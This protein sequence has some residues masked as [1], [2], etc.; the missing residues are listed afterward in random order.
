[1]NNK[2]H[3]TR[4][5]YDKRRVV[6]WKA[7]Y[8][9]F[10][11]DLINDDFTVLE[12]GAGYC[13]FINQVKCRKKIAVDAWEGF[14]AYANEDVITKVCSVQKIDFIED[15]SI[16]FVF[17]SNLFEHLSQEE[18]FATLSILRKKMKSK[19]TINIIQPNYKYSYKEYFDDFT[20]KS[21]YTE[22]SLADLLESQG[23]SVIEKR[24]RFLPLSIKSR[25]PIFPILI[26]L[27]LKSPFKLMAKQMFIRAEKI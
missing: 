16:D 24:G 18:M 13:D 26:K 25:F 20:H 6:L 23:F 7:L 22:N 12:L 15:S 11:K 21:I 9:Y 14:S 10:L 5:V 27:Y 8:D 3:C 4:F 1:M 17:A 2:Y 19:A